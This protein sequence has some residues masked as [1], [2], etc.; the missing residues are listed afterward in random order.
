MLFPA[1]DVTG[2]ADFQYIIMWAKMSSTFIDKMHAM[3]L[4][5]YTP[6]KV[7]HI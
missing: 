3:G 7:N 1:H 5:S 4:E 2:F 6:Q